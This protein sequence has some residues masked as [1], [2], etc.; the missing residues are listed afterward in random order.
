MWCMVV[1]Y[2][3]RRL[4]HRSKAP[5]YKYHADGWCKKNSYQKNSSDES[6]FLRLEGQ[7][8]VRLD[9][10]GNLEECTRQVQETHPRDV[11]FFWTEKA[12]GRKR[13]LYFEAYVY[14]VLHQNPG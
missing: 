10:N 6:K 9:L 12:N 2:R 14:Y 3:K 11:I 1:G 7:Y 4:L 5:G 13:P 8:D